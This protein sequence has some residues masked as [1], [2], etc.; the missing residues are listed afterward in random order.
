MIFA[1]LYDLSTSLTFYD[2]VNEI[3]YDDVDICD[4]EGDVTSEGSILYR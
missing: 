4:D 1:D 3:L 2:G